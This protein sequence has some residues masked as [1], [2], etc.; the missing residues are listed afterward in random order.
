M[1]LTYLP[2]YLPTYIQVFARMDRAGLVCDRPWRETAE[3]NLLTEEELAILYPTNLFWRPNWVSLLTT[4]EQQ[5]TYR[6]RSSVD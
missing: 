2:T 4:S 5:T 6:Y 1:A 3:F